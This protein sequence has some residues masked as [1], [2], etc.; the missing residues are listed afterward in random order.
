M[1][2]F[3]HSKW[4]LVWRLQC[5]PLQEKL[6]SFTEII[7]LAFGS[8]KE[9]GFPLKWFC[10]I[11][12]TKLWT[13]TVIGKP[14]KFALPSFENGSG[15]DS[16]QSSFRARQLVK[17]RVIQRHSA[18]AH[19]HLFMQPT[20]NNAGVDGNV[21]TRHTEQVALWMPINAQTGKQLCCVGYM[22]G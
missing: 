19:T 18:D 2:K 5:G 9:M 7:W 15:A 13:G 1:R 20:Q 4:S 11:M 3:L 8:E 14:S 6:T 16:L 12:L 22:L 17:Y 21:M 10:I